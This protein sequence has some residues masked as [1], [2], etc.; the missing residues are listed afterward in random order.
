MWAQNL[1]FESPLGDQSRS[2]FI[3]YPTSCLSG[4][5]LYPASLAH[6]LQLLPPMTLPRVLPSLSKPFKAAGWSLRPVTVSHGSLRYFFTGTSPL[7]E[8]QLR[9]STEPSDASTPFKT[10]TSTRK[11]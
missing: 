11:C 2:P 10:D 5:G 7:N 1:N 3:M 6:S 4:D 9:Q 8:G